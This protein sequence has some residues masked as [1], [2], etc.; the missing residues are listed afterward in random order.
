MGPS[1]LKNLFGVKS[2]FQG[3]RLPPISNIARFTMDEN[4]QYASWGVE[5]L[6]R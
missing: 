2:G 4:H 1:V 5:D 3:G 6:E